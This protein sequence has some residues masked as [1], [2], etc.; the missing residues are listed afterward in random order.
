MVTNCLNVS[1]PAKKKRHNQMSIF[2]CCKLTH[3]LPGRMIGQYGAYYWL[4]ITDQGHRGNFT[5]VDGSASDFRSWAKGQPYNGYAW[6]SES[7]IMFA[8][9]NW[10]NAPTS[11]A[12]SGGNKGNYVCKQYVGK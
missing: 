6:G 9:G 12:N 8:D 7:V 5:N 2:N 3:L 10:Y 4:G 1:V 11:A